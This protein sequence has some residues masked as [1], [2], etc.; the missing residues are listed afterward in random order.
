FCALMFTFLEK[1]RTTDCY[2]TLKAFTELLDNRFQRK[3]T[4]LLLI[5]LRK[6]IGEQKSVLKIFGTYM[7]DVLKESFKQGIGPTLE[8]LNQ[9]LDKMSSQVETLGTAGES[10]TAVSHSVNGL[11]QQLQTI[12]KAAAKIDGA[13]K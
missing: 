6:E 12:A 3:T 4:E 9:A 2:R 1:R 5:D 11:S 13:P 10:L 7:A 8:S